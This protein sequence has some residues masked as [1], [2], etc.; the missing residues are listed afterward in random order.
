MKFETMTLQE[1]VEELYPRG[2]DEFI[3]DF[4]SGFKELDE[5]DIISWND[6]GDIPDIYYRALDGMLT[7]DDTKIEYSVLQLADP[8]PEEE[9]EDDE[10]E[11]SSDIGDVVTGEAWDD[12]FDDID[13][14]EFD[15]FDGDDIDDDDEEEEEQEKPEPKPKKGKK[16]KKEKTSEGFVD[17]QPPSEETEPE[18][19]TVEEPE[20]IEIAEEPEEVKYEPAEEEIMLED[21]IDD[22]DEIEAETQSSPVST[23]AQE[24]SGENLRKAV[25]YT[26]MLLS[27]DPLR[28]FFSRLAAEGGKSGKKEDANVEN[29]VFS[30]MR[31]DL[32]SLTRVAK[33]LL[34]SKK[35]GSVH[36]G[37]WVGMLDST[38]LNKA[39]ILYGALVSTLPDDFDETRQSNSSPRYR[40]MLAGSFDSLSEDILKTLEE[41]ANLPVI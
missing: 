24:D 23:E 18:A 37:V 38:N 5:S 28:P 40:H 12:D 33:E 3:V 19:V 30:L 4:S 9:E 20:E 13:D 16:S 25:V 32:D 1:V 34:E 6:K 26:E 27:N 36:L 10:E 15:E 41:F 21:F 11:E 39:E 14:E 7:I 17:P 22:E 2:W 35:K 31:T 8:A 29:I